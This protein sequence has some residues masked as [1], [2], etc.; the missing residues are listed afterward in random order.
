MAIQR[1]ITQIR[2]DFSCIPGFLIQR[3]Q[4]LSCCF[5]LPCNRVTPLVAQVAVTLARFAGIVVVFRPESVH[6]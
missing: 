4:A 1:Q 6:Q 3:Q 5:N 2:T